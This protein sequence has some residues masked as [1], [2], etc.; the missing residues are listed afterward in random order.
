MT[1][2]P[3]PEKRRPL[4]IVLF[5]HYFAPEVGAAANRLT[6]LA[7]ML[8]ARGHQVQVVAPFPTYPTGVIPPEYRWRLGRRERID[9]LD[10]RR[11]AATPWASR[12]SSA[13][14]LHQISFMLSGGLR[15]LTF[16][17]PDVL[18]VESHPL[19]VGLAS[20]AVGRLRRIPVVLNVSDLWP[21]SA[22]AVGA[23]R[24]QGLIRLAEWMER[25]SYAGAAA[26]IAMSRGIQAGI[27]AVVGAGRRDQ[28]HLITNS[29]E[30]DRFRPEVDG[31]AIRARFG[32]PPEQFVVGYLGNLGLA[33]KLETLLEAA[34]RL[35]DDPSITILLIGGGACEPQLRAYAEALALPNVIFGG[36]LPFERMPEALAAVD[37]SAILL[38]KADVFAGVLPSKI[39]EAMAA[40]KPIAAALDGEA[41]DLIRQVG[42]GLVSPPE[43]AD[44][45]AAAIRQ[46]RDD[47]DLRAAM[48]LRGRAYAEATLAPA[49]IV[50]RIEAVLCRA[51]GL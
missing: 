36:Q 14:I 24:G 44:G 5:T 13:R 19:F 49:V 33:Q 37:V 1:A 30:A 43:D 10:V 7:R 23:L 27:L 6:R 51:A 50:D 28:V 2:V 47:P 15:L 4:R 46:L 29:V 39:F 18:L 16:S 9:G 34:H 21:A 42:V 38:R 35:R 40:G 20:W 3:A 8:Q 45:L 11:L 22:V 41:A 17:R 31:T 32:L 12:R 48:R 26:I 25:R